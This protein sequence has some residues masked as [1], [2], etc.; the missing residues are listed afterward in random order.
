MKLI[1]D[2]NVNGNQLR[3]G[4]KNIGPIVEEI[5]PVN[6][7]EINSLS[8]LRSA[9]L[10]S[11][12]VPVNFTFEDFIT[13]L[14]VKVNA[15]KTD[16]APNPKPTV[17]V[18]GQLSGQTESTTMEVGSNAS[19]YTITNTATDGGYTDAQGWTWAITNGRANDSHSDSP[20]GC[21]EGD[22]SW[23]HTN[24]VASDTKSMTVYTAGQKASEQSISLTADNIT[25]TK[26]YG[27]STKELDT[28]NNVP[29]FHSSYG[30]ALY[31]A[32]GTVEEGSCTAITTN[33][34]T[35]TVATKFYNW[36]VSGNG[37]LGNR[38]GYT[39]KQALSINDVILVPEGYSIDVHWTEMGTPAHWNTDNYE[40]ATVYIQVP[41]GESFPTNGEML[42]T[43]PTGGDKAYGQYTKYT[44]I[45]NLNTTGKGLTIDI[46]KNS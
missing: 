14:F 43:A 16:T 31:T 45:S 12:K 46:T 35:I 40:T 11:G 24:G 25:I 28:V 34:T 23:S 21:A 29:V 42:T 26:T 27:V 33:G 7:S 38:S 41:H 15:E 13:R 44:L 39:G 4:A 17:A 3:D 2:L 22:T 30:N 19:S 36:V 5:T 1:A 20:L 32:T 37:T 10:V 6:A 9:I 8:T 18:S